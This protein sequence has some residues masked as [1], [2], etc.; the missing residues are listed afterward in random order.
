MRQARSVVEE[1]DCFRDR[2]LQHFVDVQAFVLDIEDGAFEA[3]AFAIV[4]D[5]FYVGQEL[6]FDG[7]GA[8]ALAGFAA[9]AGDVEGEVS[10]G[11]AALFGVA[12]WRRRCCGSCRRL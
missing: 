12:A 3:G 9:A 6:H 11:V 4:A 5:Q 7:Y 8:V 1:F 10:G 2:Q